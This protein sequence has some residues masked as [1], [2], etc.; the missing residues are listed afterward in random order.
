[1]EADVHPFFGLIPSRAFSALLLDMG[2]VLQAEELARA[3]APVG[4]S[5]VASVCTCHSCRAALGGAIRLEPRNT[6]PAIR[7]CSWWLAAS[8]VLYR[9]SGRRMRLCEC[10]QG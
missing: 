4:F 2:P 3:G 1:M 7:R 8:A 6:G 5:A 9:G 10:A